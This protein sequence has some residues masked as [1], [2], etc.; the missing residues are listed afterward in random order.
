MAQFWQV[1]AQTL[2]EQEHQMK[3]EVAEYAL[4]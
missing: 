2:L 1:K 4:A 3:E